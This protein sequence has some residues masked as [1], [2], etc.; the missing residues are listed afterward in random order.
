MTLIRPGAAN[1]RL[2]RGGH[3]SLR[4]PG[5]LESILSLRP[6]VPVHCLRPAVF[7]ARAKRFVEAFPGNVL[8]A[9]K[10]NPDPQ[11]LQ[12]LW[13]GGVRHFDAASIGEV[14]LVRGLL[15]KAGV[16]FMH[17]IKTRGAIR[18]AYFRHRIRDFVLDST[19]ELAKIVE[20]TSQGPGRASDLGLFVRL[21][22]PP[23]G[24]LWDLSGKF[25]AEPDDAVRLLRLARMS[26]KTLGLCFHVGSQC[27]DPAAYERGLA[28]AKKVILESGVN[29]EVIDI[30][31]GFPV[32]YPDL[33]PPPLADFMAAIQ[34]GIDDLPFACE[35]WCEPGRAL[36]AP[37][38]SLV[39]QVQAR[40]ED[41]LYINDGIYGGLSDA[42]PP[43]FKYPARLLRA[44]ASAAPTQPF[45]FFGP[46]CDSVD[47]MEGPFWLPGDIDEGDWIELGQLGAYSACLRTAFNGFDEVLTVQVGDGP[48]IVTP[49]Y[50][51][52]VPEIRAA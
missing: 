29:V 2:R 27:I 19:S 15:P 51:D 11:V 17:P 37:G 42:G 6:D 3:S 35:I 46:S 28:L 49:G 4:P 1:Y 12:S 41:F 10:C 5:V 38:G 26:A 16:H 20:E 18:E 45:K 22:L 24:A 44:E 31:G 52:Q 21:A 13:A 25:G 8:Y 14:R 33:T 50:E 30:G 48:L 32:A 36:V 9:V 40:R 43:G 23:G 39:V 47:R 34:R 7:E